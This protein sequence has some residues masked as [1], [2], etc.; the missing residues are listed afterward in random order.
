M[1]R[2]TFIVFILCFVSNAFSA[3]ADNDQTL[4]ANDKRLKT[5]ASSVDLLPYERP[6]GF[7]W[8]S[9]SPGNLVSFAKR[10]RPKEN[11]WWL[12]GIGLSTA[13]LIKYDQAIMDESQR[14]ARR[15]GL[16]S[17]TKNGRET[18][19]L[20]DASAGGYDLP[21]I[22]PKNLNSVMYFIGDGLT[23]LGIISGLAG[24]GVMND[25]NR[26]LSTA[27]QTVEALFVTGVVVQVLKRT[28]GREAG[29]KAT[30]DGGKWQF[31]PNQMEYNKNVPKYD[32][33]PS[34]HLATAMATTTVLAENYPEYTYIRPLGYTLMGLLS[35]AMMNN[36]VHW[37]GDYPL[38][39]AIG[40]TAAKVAVERNRKQ[41]WLKAND[42]E[43]VS[44]M[45]FS[46]V[47]PF[48]KGDALG[49]SYVS[50]F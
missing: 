41:R 8:L 30:E 21:L 43:R 16:I 44:Q 42:P 2:L 17:D 22:F 50:N 26:S 5:S 27:S 33:F 11:A 24:Y 45:N 32:A 20:I 31:F 15:L 34:G 37:A 38:G 7:D 47:L 35:F 29:F 1:C 14:F 13:V 4:Y 48:T 36:G 23:H 49:F 19:T 3:D 40:Y 28:T 9:A 6:K 12:A 39:I 10:I 18:Y 25:D 46:A